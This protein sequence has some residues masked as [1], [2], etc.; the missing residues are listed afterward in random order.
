MISRQ[1][2]ETIGGFDPLFFHYGEDINYCQRLH[3]HKKLIAFTPWAT[4]CHDRG[5]HGNMAVYNKRAVISNLLCV[6]SNIN[7][8]AFTIKE[9]IVKFTLLLW[10]RIIKSLCS[11]KWEQFNLLVSSYWGYV[12]KIPA[13]FKSRRQNKKVGHNWL[14]I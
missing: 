9:S 10:W 7:H 5:E 11:F 13:I 12:V 4:V 14:N 6:H 8:Y 2:V 3:F 1:T